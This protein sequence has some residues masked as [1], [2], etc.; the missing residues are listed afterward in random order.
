MA[1]N[2]KYTGAQVEAYL[3]RIK[4]GDIA[5]YYLSFQVEDLYRL[6]HDASAE[7]VQVNVQRIIDAINNDRPMRAYVMLDYANY[8]GYCTAVGYIE[9][10]VYLK[11]FDGR[12]IYELEIP[13]DATEITGDNIFF[14]DLSGMSPSTGGAE[15]YI[16]DFTFVQL[17]NIAG[18]DDV[19]SASV[20]DIIGAI[21]AHRPVLV[22]YGGDIDGYS[23]L[24]GYADDF[25]Y[26]SI[27]DG[28]GV[29]LIGYAGLGADR[30]YGHLVRCIDLGF[31]SDEVAKIQE[32]V[33][34]A[35]DASADISNLYN[36]KQDTIED[37]DNIRSGAAKG[38]TALQSIDYNQIED[39][40]IDSG[41]IQT[42]DG[43]LHVDDLD[44]DIQASLS[45]ADTA[46]QE[47]QD[48][49]G[50]ADKSSL[51]TVATSGNYN[52][53]TN[54][55]TI[56]S[57]V[58]ESTVSGWGFT[59][60]TGTYSKPSGGI[61][62]SDLAADVFLKGPKGDKGDTGPQGPQGEQGPKGDKGDT[63]EQ[64]PSGTN[65]TN[66]TNGKDG[67]NGATF[68][69][70][71][72]AN[73]NLSWTNDKGLANPATVNIKG[74]K[75]DKGDS[76]SGGGGGEDIRF[77]TDFTVEQVKALASSYTTIFED[78]TAFIDA[79]RNNKLICVPYADVEKGY[80]IA[81]YKFTDG[82]EYSLRL[83]ATIFDDGANYGFCVRYNGSDYT[84]NDN[85]MTAFS[86]QIQEVEVVDGEAN[87]HAVD[88]TLYSFTDV[89][90]MLYVYLDAE[91]FLGST[92]RF[93]SGENTTID[94]YGGW[95]NGVIP[96]IEPYTDYEMSIAYGADWMPCAVLTPF[97]YV[98]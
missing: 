54:K 69:P 73:G 58:T 11:I 44:E 34:L 4:S 82:E 5:P 80:A 35:N 56:P 88:N 19:I 49:S 60:N 98:E 68:T 38:A 59:K 97:K 6:V 66:G 32:V 20:Q 75:G 96:T 52:D 40:L 39:N 12:C 29:Q 33:D 36:T 89:V 95:A 94:Y 84:V 74:P 14:Y 61:P 90:E 83:Y 10:F 55:P 46:L 26:F 72:D 13:L 18:T 70:S 43:V 79:A 78:A 2:S 41:F 17:R 9:D 62:A 63:G 81:S 76:G 67:V 27:A 23:L 77:F 42:T 85:G 57:A 22:P 24:L 53:L 86:T 93:M 51:A 48:I 8:R 50:K 1:Y 64:G 16:T 30:I 92:I 28:G 65:G 31:I 91:L 21:V 25:F 37:L 87:V 15:P 71:V 3:D 45:K 47:H 7:P